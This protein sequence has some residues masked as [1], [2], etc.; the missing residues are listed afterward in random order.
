MDTGVIGSDWDLLRA[1]DRQIDSL[2]LHFMFSS[3]SADFVVTVLCFLLFFSTLSS[4]SLSFSLWVS[5]V[6]LSRDVQCCSALCSACS[7]AVTHLS[8]LSLCT[9]HTLEL[10]TCTCTHM[11]AYTV[12]CA[13]WVEIGLKCSYKLQCDQTSGVYLVLLSESQCEYY[14]SLILQPT[15]SRSEFSRS[16]HC[17]NRE[18]KMFPR[19]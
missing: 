13:V 17:V 11:R 1:R 4:V 8:L 12:S 5:A 15:V 2:Q 18:D 14:R 7:P 19:Q 9:G 16:R 10:S 6:C 3:L